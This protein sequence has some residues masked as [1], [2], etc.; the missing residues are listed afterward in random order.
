MLVGSTRKARLLT[1]GT[2]VAVLVA[3]AA[4]VALDPADDDEIRRDAY[5]IE[6]DRICVAAKSQIVAEQR[7]ALS[8]AGGNA[9]AVYARSLVPI[10]ATWRLGLEELGRPADRTAQ[11]LDLDAAL[12]EVEIELAGLALIADEGS[13]G[14]T[15][16]LA[17]DVDAASASV[18]RAISALGLRDCSRYVVGFA[19]R[20]QG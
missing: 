16:A 14:P 1:A 5:T 7:R 13:P 11:I 9:G 17:A 20:P 6:A 2:A 8:G 12:R 3:I 18:E 4:F 19:P 10:V 15:D